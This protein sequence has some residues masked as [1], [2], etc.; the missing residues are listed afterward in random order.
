MTVWLTTQRPSAGLKLPNRNNQSSP[1][2]L[3]GLTSPETT[4]SQ[5]DQSNIQT[6]RVLSVPPV[7]NTLL[8]YDLD[9]MLLPSLLSSILERRLIHPKEV[10]I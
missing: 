9:L 2:C 6:G 5:V 1:N 4:K 7:L 10:A 3:Q 8:R